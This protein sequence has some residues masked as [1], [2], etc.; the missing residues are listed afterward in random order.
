M[1]IVLSALNVLCGLGND[2]YREAVS[3]VFSLGV[4]CLTI[5]LYAERVYRKQN[6]RVDGTIV[7]D[8]E[9]LYLEGDPDINASDTVRFRVLRKR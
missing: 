4:L 5:S 9:D 1:L 2:P 8:G 6:P 3:T 7:K